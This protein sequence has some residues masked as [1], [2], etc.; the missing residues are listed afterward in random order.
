MPCRFWT[1][2]WC[3]FL[4]LQLIEDGTLTSIIPYLIV[5]T[6]LFIGFTYICLDTAFSVSGYFDTVP[7]TLHNNWI[8]T[9]LIVLCGAFVLFTIVTSG[10]VAGMFLR[11]RRPICK[12][13]SGPWHGLC[14]AHLGADLYNKTPSADLYAASLFFFA[15]SQGAF[16]ALSQIVCINTNS[17]IDG[18]FLSTICTIISVALLYFAWKVRC[19]LCFAPRIPPEG[20]SDRSLPASTFSPPTQSV[21]EDSW[22][23]VATQSMTDYDRLSARPGSSHYSTTRSMSNAGLG[24]PGSHYVQATSPLQT[25]YPYSD[26]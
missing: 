13:T 15:L 16:W 10:W 22:D 1:L 25:N 4:E 7:E 21:T 18:S 19:I 2:A 24:G 8:F 9:I 26:R 12:S 3:T 6:I 23:E 17:K 5:S 20:R 14:S 11:E